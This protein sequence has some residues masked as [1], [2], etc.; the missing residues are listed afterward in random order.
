MPLTFKAAPSY[1]WLKSW[2][3]ANIIEQGTLSFCNRFVDF[4]ID[5]QRRLYDQMMM[6]A[7]SIRANIAEGAGRHETSYE[8]E[9]RLTDVARGSVHELMGDCISFIM[10]S[11]L[12]TWNTSDPKYLAVLNYQ[13]AKPAYSDNYIHDAV[14]HI[15]S[16]K[17]HFDVFLEHGSCEDAANCIVVLCLKINA[18]LTKMLSAQLRDFKQEGGFAENLTKSRLETRSREA[19][20]SGAPSCPKCGKQMLLRTVR[21]GVG[22]GSQF[23]SCSDYPHCQGARSLT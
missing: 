9:M 19:A 1:F 18:M 12:Q 17:K 13:L 7:R 21:R 16:E 2:V 6:A 5:P 23:W 10:R 22:Q 20:D 4:K 3:L 11:S 8:T 15:L 14:K